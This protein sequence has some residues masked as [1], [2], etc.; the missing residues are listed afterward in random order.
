APNA[1]RDAAPADAMDAPDE[2]PSQAPEEP[3]APEEAADPSAEPAD[4]ARASE[5]EPPPARSWQPQPM[6]GGR[7]AFALATVSL[8]LCPIGFAGFDVWPLSFVA[9]VPLILALRGQPTKRAVA[10]GWYAGFGM[11]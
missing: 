2:P 5:P 1:D 6:L 9:W 11:T 3:P 8:V 10:L 7:A 4:Q